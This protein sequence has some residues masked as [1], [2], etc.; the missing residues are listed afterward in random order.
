MKGVI[1]K[2]AGRKSIVLFQNGDFRAIPTPPDAQI[3]MAIT[4]LYNRRLI[5]IFA[6]AV[7]AV[8][9]AVVSAIVL[10]FSPVGYIDITYGK[11]KEQRITVELVVNRFDRILDANISSAESGFTESLPLFKHKGLNEGYTNAI[12][13]A[14]LYPATPKILLQIT[15]KDTRRIE[16]LKER[17][18][19][20]TESLEAKTGRILSPTFELERRRSHSAHH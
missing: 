2:I 17:L 9:I 12:I 11:A 13:T 10:Y 6:A 15:H 5:A 14:S 1:W 20:L 4:V 18:L 16:E 7:Y 8:V 3:G 19:R